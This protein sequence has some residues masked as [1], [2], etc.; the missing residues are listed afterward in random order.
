MFYELVERFAIQNET[1]TTLIVPTIFIKFGGSN[2]IVTTP[3]DYRWIAKSK[4]IPGRKWD[5][6]TMSNL[7]PVSESERVLSM[8]RECF[9]EQ[10]VS[11]N[12]GEFVL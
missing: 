1:E 7:F 5:W 9:R 12:Q 11:T 4:K 6:N 3:K 10:I 2:L 8:L